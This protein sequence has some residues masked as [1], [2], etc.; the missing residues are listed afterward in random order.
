MFP[1]EIGVCCSVRVSSRLSLGPRTFPDVPGPG[2]RLGNAERR[3]RGAKSRCAG[4]PR[5]SGTGV[6]PGPIPSLFREKGREGSQPFLGM[7]PPC[8]RPP[9]S[10][11]PPPLCRGA[12]R[13]PLH[14]GDGMWALPADAGVTRSWKYRRG[15]LGERRAAAMCIH[16][17]GC[18]CTHT[19]AHRR[20]CTRGSL[21]D[22]ANDVF[23]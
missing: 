16:P 23:C 21:L 3:E 4:M 19:R 2:V 10:R 9:R 15:P 14:L 13:N 8:L 12:H 17:C 18:L 6:V 1:Q 7:K 20:V 11:A 5:R 22:S